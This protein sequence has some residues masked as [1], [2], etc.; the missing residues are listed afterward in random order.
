MGPSG[1]DAAPL[2]LPATIDTLEALR[3][4]RRVQEAALA[5]RGL[6]ADASAV[7]EIGLAGLQLLALIEAAV[8]RDRGSFALLAPSSALRGR[9]ADAGLTRLLSDA[10]PTAQ[11]GSLP[12]HRLTF[13]DTALDYGREPIEALHRMRTAG[14]RVE[15]VLP[16]PLPAIGSIEADRLL[17]GFNVYLPDGAAAGAFA[18]ALA[19]FGGDAQID[20]PAHSAQDKAATTERVAHLAIDPLAAKLE[21]LMTDVEELMARQAAVAVHYPSLDRAVVAELKAM[22]GALRNLQDHAIAAGLIPLSTLLQREAAAETMRAPSFPGSDIEIEPGVLQP[23]LP[24]LISLV[25]RSGGVIDGLFAQEVDGVLAIEVPAA[26][27]EAALALVEPALALV[28][29]RATIRAA[30]SGPRLRLE[31]PRSRSM[32]EALIVRA[33]DQLAAIPVD[34]TIEILRPEPAD[35]TSVGSGAQLMRFRGGYLSIVDLAPALGRS[36]ASGE[37]EAT[38]VVVIQSGAGNFG[39]RVRE[40]TDHR[41]IMVKPL[42]GGIQAGAGV[43]GVSFSAGGIALVLDVDALRLATLGSPRST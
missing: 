5:S 8:A 20:A 34:R 33:G 17:L 16:D 32:L 11:G 40:V 36:D 23:L 4:S 21:R 1:K 2:R 9:I 38:V 14:I 42:D 35:L 25:A 28:R 30:E 43:V 39:I 31:L 41:Q 27:A 10:M 37:T 6:A 12:H 18:N 13:R 26:D 7:E 24:A 22:D 29:G 15:S 19:E 3:L